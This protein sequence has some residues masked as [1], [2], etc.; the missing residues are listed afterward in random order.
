MGTRQMLGDSVEGFVTT[1]IGWLLQT[2][3]ENIQRKK[4]KLKAF[5]PK[6]R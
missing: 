6:T 1:S 3:L 2:T 4:T 5:H